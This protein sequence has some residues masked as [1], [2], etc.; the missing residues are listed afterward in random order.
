MLLRMF[1]H[2]AVFTIA[3]ALGALAMNGTNMFDGGKPGREHSSGYTSG[4]TGDN[5]FWQNDDDH[6][7]KRREH[8][9]D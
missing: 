6:S 3:I 2:S 4:Y 9:D 1:V 5:A 7:W 8:D